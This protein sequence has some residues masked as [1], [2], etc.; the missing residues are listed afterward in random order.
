MIQRCTN[1]NNPRFQDYGARGIAVCDEWRQFENFYADMGDPPDGMSIDRIQN[2]RGYSKGN[3]HWATDKQQARNMRS[4]RFVAINGISK[5][6]AEWCDDFNVKYWTVHSRIR[7]GLSP[8]EA[9]GQ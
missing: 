2:D 8:I 3:C 9:L 7:R 6:L 5:P 4:N 1:E